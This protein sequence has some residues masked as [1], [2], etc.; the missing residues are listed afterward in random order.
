MKRVLFGLLILGIACGDAPEEP[1]PE[2]A[3]PVAPKAAPEPV[4]A[5]PPAPVREIPRFGSL[6][7]EGS[8]GAVAFLGGE[9]LGTL[10]GRFA[11]LEPGSYPLRVE[12]E[13]HHPLEVEVTIEPGEVRVISAVLRERLGSLV[14]ESDRPGAMVFLDRNFKGNTPVTVS[15][16]APGEYQ[17]TVSLEGFDVH[18]ERIRVERMPVPVDV[19]FGDPIPTLDAAV[20]VVHKHTFGSCE[21][22][23]EATEE[24]FFYR[25]EHQDAFTLSFA[26]TEAF[27]LDYLDNN[28]RLKVRGGRT[29]NFESPD[30]D[31]D[32]LFVFHRDVVAY[33]ETLR[34]TE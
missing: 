24:G 30:E 11:S 16:L 14:V 32:A 13:N 3:A 10:P 1:A 6:H 23:L 17:I 7:V 12:M 5:P 15:D 27:E 4:P 33:R 29:Y 34:T 21:G 19:V 18:S 28:L 22:S 31:M 8:E 20:P 26:D 9:R 2:E 25:T